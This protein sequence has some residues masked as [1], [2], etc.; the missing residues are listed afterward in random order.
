MPLLGGTITCS[1]TY[2]SIT[3]TQRANKVADLIN[4]LLKLK[5]PQLCLTLMRV[6]AGMC[7]MIYCFRTTHPSALLEA[8]D[9]LS[10]AIKHALVKIVVGIGS[11]FGDFQLQLASL[12]PVRFGGLGITKE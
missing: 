8:S 7:K 6:C 11:F 12:P 10:S 9:V 1:S 5:D 3:A 4:T 2:A